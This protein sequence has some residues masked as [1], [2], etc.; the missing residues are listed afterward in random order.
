MKPLRTP[1]LL[2]CI[3]FS[4]LIFTNVKASAYLPKADI[5][6]ALDGSGKFKSIQEA[7]NAVPDNSA[8]R[9]VILIKNGVY[10]TEK[11]IVPASKINLT[12][13]GESRGKTV[14]SYH[15]YDCKS[16][17][18]GNKCPA[19]S[20]ALWKDNKELIRTSATLTVLANNFIAENLTVSNTAGPVGQALALTLRADKVIF[21]HC[22]I[23]G[24]QDT[25]LLGKDGMLNYF[26][27]CLI[28]GRTDYIYGGG[29]GYFQ[30]CEIRSYGG[31]WVTAPSTPETQPY[32]YVFNQ[33]KFT[34]A[35]NSP[36]NGDDGRK[37]A[38]GRPWHNYPKVA[39]LNSE[40]CEQMHPE[41]WPTIWNM[42]YAATSDKLHLYE[43]H[44]TGKG[45]DM[46]SRAKWAG[47]RALTA[48]E[49]K[50]YTRQV[51]LKDWNPLLDTKVY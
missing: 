12:I 15:L 13:L 25:I 20:W 28:L 6:V 22:N 3:L 4:L 30:S 9:T 51:V 38:I 23:L 8:K 11:L 31:G 40:M 5:V 18:S 48:E 36:R 33:C 34:Y 26:V 41:G 43:Y 44:N 37:I 7:I 45:A 19:E 21:N 10:N 29:I 42:T 1:I 46:S 16:E 24:Y 2:T 17:A 49:A 47:L 14:V 32:G 39:I 35:D 50:N 27:D